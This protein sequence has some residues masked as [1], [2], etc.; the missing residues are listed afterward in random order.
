MWTAAWNTIGER[1]R[2]TPEY[3]VDRV[4]E[5]IMAQLPTT[6][7]ELLRIKSLVADPYFLACRATFQHRRD[8]REFETRLEPMEWEGAK[9]ALKIPDVFV[10]TMCFVR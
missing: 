1:P 2:E 5:T 3:E 4:R 6:V 10:A 7:R 8:G 9:W